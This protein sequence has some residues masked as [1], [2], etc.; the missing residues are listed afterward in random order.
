MSAVVHSDPHWGVRALEFVDA[1]ERA[2][3]PADVETLFRANIAQAGFGAY[4]MCGLPDAQADFKNRVLANGWPTE[5]SRLYLTENLAK[6]DP[7]ER[8]CLRSVNPFD[9]CNAPYDSEAEPDAGDVM[10]RAA[11]FG[12]K[13]GF[14][15]PIHY[16]DGP[17]AAVSISGEQPDLGPGVRPAMHLMALY[18]HHRVRSLIGHPRN[19]AGHVLTD[20][21][22]EVLNWAVVGK[23][24]WEIGVILKISE[25]TAR[26]H[27]ANAAKKL[28]ASNRTHTVVEALRSG[29]VTL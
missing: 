17:G 16:G 10:R 28:H 29:E 11:E 26:A 7:V 15:V 20:R 24:D 25:R 2:P 8:H 12:L 23:T 3:T 5:W 22:R 27:M 18:A 21:E 4:V 9:W 6:N 19:K 13:K 1:V 14:C